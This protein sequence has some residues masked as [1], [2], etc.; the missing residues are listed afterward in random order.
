M[1]GRM[2][3]PGQTNRSNQHL[4]RVLF[5][6]LTNSL[7]EWMSLSVSLFSLSVSFNL[8]LPFQQR[9]KLKEQYFTQKMKMLLFIRAFLKRVA[10]KDLFSYFS[11]ERKKSVDNCQVPP[12]SR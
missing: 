8:P 3:F 2:V 9:Y 10:S 5:H 6:F 1:V 7:D 11:N 12:P 4:R